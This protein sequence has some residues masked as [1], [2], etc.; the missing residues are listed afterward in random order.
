M[1][2]VSWGTKKKGQ[3]A[4]LLLKWELG[5][6]ESKVTSAAENKGRIKKRKT[7]CIPQVLRE[8]YIQARFNNSSN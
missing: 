4:W 6:Y 2:L 5:S 8:I 1:D 7:A 3:A